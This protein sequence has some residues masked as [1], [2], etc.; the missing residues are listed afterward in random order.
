MLN[1]QGCLKIIDRKKNIFKLAQGEGAGLGRQP[2]GS[3]VCLRVW[4]VGVG[5]SVVAAP[6]APPDGACAPASR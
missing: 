3:C 5:A 4:W 1:E 2:G 6:S